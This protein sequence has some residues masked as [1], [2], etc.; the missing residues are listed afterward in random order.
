MIYTKKPLTVDE[1][2]DRLEQRGLNFSDR[3]LENLQTA[4]NSFKTGL[5]KRQ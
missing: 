5:I 2:I 1:Q 3:K 4:I